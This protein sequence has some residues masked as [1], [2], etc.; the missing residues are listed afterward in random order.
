MTITGA[1]SGEHPSA[2]PRSLGS[3]RPTDQAVSHP[4]G[5]LSSFSQRTRRLRFQNPKGPM[6]PVPFPL[7]A[8]LLRPLASW[9]LDTFEGLDPLLVGIE[10]RHDTMALH[11][12]H[13]DPI[14]PL[15]DVATL[16]APD[17]WSAIVLLID[18]IH[19]SVALRQW[20]SIS[21]V[22]A[23][24]ADRTGE[25]AGE[26]DSGHGARTTLDYGFG[27]LA[28]LCGAFFAADREK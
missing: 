28:Q 18:V 2:P 21:G 17:S 1:H 20:I 8:P 24:A 6:S 9:C 15:Q 16:A 10:F 23:L 26:L 3:T 19:A 22:L 27:S 4:T 25:V 14:D 5:R 11:P 12:V 13:L 7:A